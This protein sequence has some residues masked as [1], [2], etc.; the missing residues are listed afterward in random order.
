MPVPIGNIGSGSY[1]TSSK[2]DGSKIDAEQIETLFEEM[3]KKNNKSQENIAGPAAAPT[4][5]GWF[6]RT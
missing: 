3:D 1:G 4:R 5:P 2:S 6:T